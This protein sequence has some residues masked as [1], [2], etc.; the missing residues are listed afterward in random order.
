MRPPLTFVYGN[1]AFADGLGDPWAAFAVSLDSYA[2]LDRDQK[3]AR[4]LALV[5]AI[6]AAE[7][8]VQILRVAG[9]WDPG[10]YGADLGA[11]AARG[12]ECRRY[13][14]AQQDEL[15]VRGSVVP[16]LYLLVSLNEPEL[17][18]ASY[19]SA[20]ASHPAAD[21]RARLRRAASTLERRTLPAR[22]LERLRVRADR[23]ER[24]LADFL[25]VRAAR[26]VELQWLTRRCFCRG[27]G[28]P[29]V[30]NLHSP[31]AL[32]FERNGEAVL[33]PLEGDILRW[34]NCE[35]DQRV[36]CSGQA[37]ARSGKSSR[38]IPSLRTTEAGVCRGRDGG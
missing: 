23:V 28:E 2:W 4:M 19:L 20:A 26:G 13:V 10:A 37:C 8:D 16:S 14:E 5:G 31:R 35:I 22:E 11:G 38:T 9:R 1:C 29:S 12:P 17:D 24:R 36:R 21:L 18:L 25:P 7:A 15:R 6:E 34:L 27:L 33:A 32:A 30:E 3:R